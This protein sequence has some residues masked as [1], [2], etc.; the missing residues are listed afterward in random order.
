MTAPL[1]RLSPFRLQE[2]SGPQHASSKDLKAPKE[3]KIGMMSK[4]GFSVRVGLNKIAYKAQSLGARMGGKAGINSS[5]KS[6]APGKSSPAL[7]EDDDDDSV[8]ALFA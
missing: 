5:R 4:L 7:D 1:N 3:F 2:K 8:D 6:K